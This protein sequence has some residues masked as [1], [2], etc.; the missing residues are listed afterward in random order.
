MS[1]NIEKDARKLMGDY[2]PYVQ[3]DYQDRVF[4]TRVSQGKDAKWNHIFEFQVASLSDEV[5]FKLID[6]DIFVPEAIGICNMK[7]SALCINE[8]VE[9]N[10]P[11]YYGQEQVAVLTVLTQYTPI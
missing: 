7:L 1:A 11:V 9:C 6:Y 5:L 10:F 4:K 8:G 3:F 2:R